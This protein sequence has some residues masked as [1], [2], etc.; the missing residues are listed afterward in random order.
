M[1]N[2][3]QEEIR[4]VMIPLAAA[5]PS[6]YKKGLIIGLICAYL[7]LLISYF[8]SGALLEYMF[9]EIGIISVI[10]FISSKIYD[11][12]YRCHYEDIIDN[13]MT[14]VII[15]FSNK[16]LILSGEE[17]LKEFDTDEITVRNVKTSEK[18]AFYANCT[19]ILEC[20]KNGEIIGMVGVDRLKEF[21]G[22]TLTADNSRADEDIQVIYDEDPDDFDEDSY[23]E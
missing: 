13:S 8:T 12:I 20:K 7:M 16:L 19:T 14:G 17:V 18:E 1:N 2:L 6:I 15:G 9:V 3:N 4:N 23:D 22:L 11:Y 10:L 21:E 5:R